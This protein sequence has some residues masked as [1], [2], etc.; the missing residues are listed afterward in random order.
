MKSFTES[1]LSTMREMRKSGSS[2]REIAEAVGR[3]QKSVQ[4]RIYNTEAKERK[5]LKAKGAQPKRAYKLRKYKAASE[6]VLPAAPTTNKKPLIVFVGDH[7]EV[8]A[9]IKELFS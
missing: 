4:N 6:T 8:T 5:Q 7:S 9:A 3:T 2:M 1:D